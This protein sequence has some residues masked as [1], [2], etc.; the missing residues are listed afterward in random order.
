MNSIVMLSAP[1]DTDCGKLQLLSQLPCNRLPPS[2]NIW[3][4]NPLPI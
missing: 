4:E 1:W 3:L 2:G